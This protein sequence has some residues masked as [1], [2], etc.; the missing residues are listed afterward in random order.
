MNTVKATFSI[1]QEIMDEL[2]NYAKES[3]LKK[4]NVV[5]SALEMFFDYM[6]LKIA[7]ER[8]D[9]IKTKNLKCLSI[10]EIEKEL[11]L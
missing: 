2:N 7:K 9:E 1:P 3:G 6:D 4:S 11:R 10:E 8:I 5:V